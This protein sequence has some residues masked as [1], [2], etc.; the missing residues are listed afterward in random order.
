MTGKTLLQHGC[1]RA[2]HSDRVSWKVVFNHTRCPS[3]T[4]ALLSAQ[5]LYC[6]GDADSIEHSWEAY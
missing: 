3:A 2:L 4:Y 6:V 1:E 5:E